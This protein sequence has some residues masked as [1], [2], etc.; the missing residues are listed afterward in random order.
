MSTNRANSAA[1]STNSAN[2]AATSGPAAANESYSVPISNAVNSYSMYKKNVGNMLGLSNSNVDEIEGTLRDIKWGDIFKR[3]SSQL[4][5]FAKIYAAG[6][7]NTPTA[8]NNATLNFVETTAVT[9][10]TAN[11]EPVANNNN[12]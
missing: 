6:N 8:A 4:T 10:G 2:S 1:M 9:N 5:T 3:A 11:N 12:N 7:N